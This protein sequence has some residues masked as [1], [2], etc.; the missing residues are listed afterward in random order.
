MSYGSYVKVPNA[1]SLLKES[2]GSSLVG[3]RNIT[4]EELFD[5][6]A[7]VN[8]YHSGT[9]GAGDDSSVVNAAIASGK[10]VVFLGGDWNLESVVPNSDQ[11]IVGLLGATVRPYSNASIFEAAQGVR[12]A[13]LNALG[14]GKSSG[15]ANEIFVRISG[16]GQCHVENNNIRGMGGAG[17]IVRE[18]YSTY[19]GST[20]SNNRVFDCANGIDLQE[21]GEYCTV[22]VNTIVDNTNG[23]IIVGGNNKALGNTITRNETGLLV[24][25]GTNDAHGIVVGNVINHNPINAQ[26]NA[27]NVEEMAFEGNAFY[28]GKIVLN[29]CY[30]ATFRGGLIESSVLIEEKGAQECVFRGVKFPGGINNTPNDGAASK[31]LY[32]DCDLDRAV[33]IATATSINGAYSESDRNA[34]ATLTSGS[35]T[36]AIMNRNISNSITANASFTVEQLHITGTNTFDVEGAVVERGFTVQANIQVSVSRTGAD[37]DIDS[38]HCL[39]VDASNSNIVY[40]VC[41]ASPKNTLTGDVRAH[42]FSFNGELPRKNFQIKLINDSANDVTILADQTDARTKAIITKW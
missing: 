9:P 2:A 41:V 14:S 5:T 31:V 3:Y 1:I 24:D 40:G 33:S 12:V 27:L 8:A 30:G 10:P 26:V 6:C 32:V 7:V 15:N 21:R 29:G 20:I 38:L 36:L 23:L 35:S 19:D 37:V 42:T 18:Y 11:W 17:V 25:V 4:L 22:N 16:E 34:A 13:G 39:V 28:A